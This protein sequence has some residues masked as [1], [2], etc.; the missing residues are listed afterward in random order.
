MPLFS[1]NKKTTFLFF[2]KG[3]GISTVSGRRKDR[4]REDTDFA[5]YSGKQEWVSIIHGNIIDVRISSR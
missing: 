5:Q 2:L 1:Q 4:E 3:Q